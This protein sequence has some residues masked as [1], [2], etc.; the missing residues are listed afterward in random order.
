[1]TKLKIMRA[2]WPAF[3]NSFSKQHRDW[4]V[5]VEINE[6]G[7]PSILG[8]SL[9]LKG[10]SPDGKN[11][12]INLMLGNDNEDFE[13]NISDPESIIL[14]Q[15]NEGA[16]KELQINSVNGTVTTLRFISVALPE[17]VDGMVYK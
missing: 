16:H 9:P 17:T 6:T 3:L 11:K 13:H 15:T 10:I 12:F 5:T 1:M 7:N 8:K 4:L 14:D 2:E